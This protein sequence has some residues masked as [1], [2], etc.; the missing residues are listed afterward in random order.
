MFVWC[1][2]NKYLSE[3]EGDGSE[4]EWPAI[5]V[6]EVSL[7]SF[8]P[9]QHFIINVGDVQDQTNNQRQT[10]EGRGAQRDYEWK[11]IL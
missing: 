3:Q 9:V 5:L 11:D 8:G 6:A 7:I 4:C 2:T 1:Y 10:Y